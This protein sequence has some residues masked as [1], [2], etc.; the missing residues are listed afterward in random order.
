MLAVNGIGSSGYSSDRHGHADSRGTV[1]RID[2]R[3]A[4]R[5]GRR[6][7]SAVLTWLEPDT[8]GSPITRYE[9][10]WRAS[11]Q[12]FSKLSAAHPSRRTT[13]TRD[14]AS[15]TA[16]QYFFQVRAVNSVGSS[17]WSNEATAI[18]SQRLMF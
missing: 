11:G 6:H 15:R 18:A 4:G 5:V 8:G 13:Y 12:A 14:R 1:R 17:T 16:R 3:A 10:Q 9:V 7:V 2:A